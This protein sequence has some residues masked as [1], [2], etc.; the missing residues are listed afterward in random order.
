MTS[1]IRYLILSLPILAGDY[2]TAQTN[3]FIDEEQATVTIIGDPI[4]ANNANDFINVNPYSD[5]NNPPV[6][7]YQQLTQSDRYIEPTLENGFHIRFEIGSA[8]T[9]N[10][11]GSSS[12]FS[13]EGY[14]KAKKHAVSM[15]ERSFNMKKRMKSWLPERKKK[16]R[17]HRCGRF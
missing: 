12:S 8:Q 11:A 9:V 15:T 1:I 3:L 6:Q 16:Y 5:N 2:I 7:Q 14:G 10:N 4:Q 17:P 13:G